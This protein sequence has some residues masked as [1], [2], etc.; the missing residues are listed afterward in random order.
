[1]AKNSSIK[2][3]H[4]LYSPWLLYKQNV[5]FGLKRPIIHSSAK[6]MLMKTKKLNITAVIVC[7]LAS[8]FYLYDF[9][10]RVMPSAMTDEL[11]GYFHIG[12]ATLGVMVAVFYYAYAVMQIPAGLMFDRIGTRLLLTIMVLI[13]AVGV[14][15]FGISDSII[16]ATIGRFLIGFS[17]AFAFLG[18]L[19]MAARWLPHKY[20]ALFVG[21]V[22][23]LGCV[24]AIAGG[25]P[26]AIAVKH[27][28]W[29]TTNFFVALIG[30]VLAILFWV[31]LRDHPEGATDEQKNFHN[32]RVLAQLK[33]VFKNKQNWCIAIYA[34]AIWA[35]T[36]IFAVLWGVPFI[37][38]LYH[39]DATSAT[40]AVSF[41]W[42]GI[43]I[44]CPL[45]GWWSDQVGLRRLPMIVTSLLGIVMSCIIIYLN[46]LSI[47]WMYAV[48]FLFGIAI[49]SMVISFGLIT[50]INSSTTVGTANGFN[51][52]AILIGGV[53]FQP[54][55]GFVLHWLWEGNLVNHIP[56]Y[57]LHSY[58][59]A[60]SMIPVCFLLA[61]IAAVFFIKETYCIG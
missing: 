58:K 60:L 35:P 10:V 14:L 11:M 30:V 24:G 34:F 9:L 12:A 38:T 23:L 39:L 33:S 45:I 32:I 21:L 26:I 42:I 17:S 47:H 29:R 57:T 53:I 50:D 36:T 5:S 20:F 51:N 15:L 3:N 56:V 13:C 61:F 54:M 27:F 28:G 59:V 48:L 8:L 22:Q 49:S 2:V 4:L 46:I 6:V 19:V 1:M 52:M 31:L 16:I 43:G 55:V 40:I 41:V 25:G 37:K 44:G 18:A 7:T